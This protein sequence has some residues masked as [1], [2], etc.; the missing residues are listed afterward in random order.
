VVIASATRPEDCGFE[1]RVVRFC[2][3]IHSNTS[4]EVHNLISLLL[5][6]YGKTK[7]KKIVVFSFLFEREFS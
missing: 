5:C 4:K 3:L 7:C 6:G 2:G 1:S